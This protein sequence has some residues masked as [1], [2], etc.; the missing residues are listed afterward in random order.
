[1]SVGTLW[2]VLAFYSFWTADHNRRAQSG[3]GPATMMWILGRGVSESG[4][5][6]VRA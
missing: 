1:M 6:H 2:G 3:D 5:A 4:A